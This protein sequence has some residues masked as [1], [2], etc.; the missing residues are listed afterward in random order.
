MDQ[1]HWLTIARC[2]LYR[3][4]IIFNPVPFVSEAPLFTHMI[5]VCPLFLVMEPLP[6]D[7]IFPHRME[8]CAEENKR[9]PLMA[10][11]AL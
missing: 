8:V 3:V 5:E 9:V 10:I 2:E 1:A 7:N 4:V 6:L 11:D